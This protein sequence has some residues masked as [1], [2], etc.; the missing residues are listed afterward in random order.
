M[1]GACYCNLEVVGSNHIT[2][3][4]WGKKEKKQTY[5]RDMGS[6]FLFCAAK[7]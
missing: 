1:E 7:C 2:S 4:E 6:N 5:C 3:Q